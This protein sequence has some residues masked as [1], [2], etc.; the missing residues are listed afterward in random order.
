[1]PIMIVKMKGYRSF[2]REKNQ[3]QSCRQE[4]TS[5]PSS[6]GSHDTRKV[7]SVE[8]VSNPC[9]PFLRKHYKQLVLRQW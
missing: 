1:M 2:E 5:M 7:I 4:T 3:Q 9:V 8:A 6:R